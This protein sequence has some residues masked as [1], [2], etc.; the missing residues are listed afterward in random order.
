MSDTKTLSYA[1]LLTITSGVM[2]CDVGEFHEACEW[3]AGHPV[4]T[5]ELADD[6]TIADIRSA[7]LAIAPK[8]ADFDRRG[9]TKENYRERVVE[10]VE[11]N[12]LPHFVV[13]PKREATRVESPMESAERMFGGKPIVE[14]DGDEA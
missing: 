3:L 10:F 7:A 9:I 13:V 12:D 14:V 8:C 5:H 1:A 11:S 6:A 2:L 4:W